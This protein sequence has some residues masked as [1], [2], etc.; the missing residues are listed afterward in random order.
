MT[1]THSASSKRHSFTI[2]PLSLSPST[3]TF[4][5]PAK[6]DHHT[7]TP[8]PLSTTPSSSSFSLAHGHGRK[9]HHAQSHP[10]RQS[11]ISYIKSPP[12]GRLQTPYSAGADIASFD[13]SPSG[14]SDVA[15]NAGGSGAG[16]ARSASLGRARRSTMAAAAAA[17]P[18]GSLLRGDIRRNSS[19]GLGLTHAPVGE[20]ENDKFGQPLERRRGPLTPAEKHAELLQF[21]A[22]KE[23]ICLELRSQLAVHEAELVQLKRKWELIVS[24]G[25][26]VPFPANIDYLYNSP[27]SSLRS[28]TAHPTA[29][30]SSIVLEG[31]KEGM[32]GVSRLIL[33]HPITPSPAPPR[34]ASSNSVASS[35]H[36][37]RSHRGAAPPSVGE[38]ANARLSQSSTSSVGTN[39]SLASST[40]PGAR[41][42]K[43]ASIASTACTSVVSGEDAD[44]DAEDTARMYTMNDDLR[45]TPTGTATHS[46]TASIST[47]EQEAL[48]LTTAVSI[49]S[50]RHDDLFG[51]SSPVLSSGQDVGSPSPGWSGN[52]RRRSSGHGSA[53]SGVNASGSGGAGPS[54]AHAYMGHP[55]APTPPMTFRAAAVEEQDRE[56]LDS[57]VLEKVAPIQRSSSTGAGAGMGAGGGLPAGATVHG[58]GLSTIAA[59]AVGAQAMETLGRKWDEL[60]KGSSRLAK[61]QKR[62]S[63]M[64]SDFVSS[65]A[66]S[67]SAVQA[68]SPDLTMSPSTASS[69]SSL[70]TNASPLISRSTPISLLDDDDDMDASQRSFE[71]GGVLVPDRLPLSPAKAVVSCRKDPVGDLSSKNAGDGEEDEWNW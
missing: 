19:F 5:T 64:F 1:S 51:L 60:A 47:T 54:Y 31:I 57:T 2:K 9:V 32:Q 15:S 18:G 13:D 41:A 43:R 26:D 22:Q 62:A 49:D 20:E 46:E 6:H 45:A 3:S 55:M 12:L 7:S 63:L 23:S 27:N 28:G 56:V 34:P 40:G 8:T 52:L 68:P 36:G 14:K 50:P 70:R 25:L 21:I 39:V 58:L 42:E 67:T 4:S 69:V 37:N 16:L 29:T 44:G 10:R 17:S 24:R 38:D 35:R 71:A 65:L 30:S 61:S 59:G 11:S 66:P 33:G 53:G 48:T